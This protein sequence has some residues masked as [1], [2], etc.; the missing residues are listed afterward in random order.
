MLI[1][2]Y[3]IL[4]K[5]K[6]FFCINLLYFSLRL[7]FPLKILL[8]T[9]AKEENKYIKEFVEHY[10]KLKVN[11]IIIYDNN[12]IDSENFT[13][14]LKNE[15]SNN[16]VKIINYRGFEQPQIKAL[17]DCY[18]R[19]NKRYDWIAFYDVDEFLHII[20]YTDL[21]KFMSLKRFKKCQSILINWKYYG[22]NDL[23]YYEPKPLS[24]RFTKPFYFNSSK[25]SLKYKVS[26][27]KTIVRGGLKIEWSHLPHYLKNTINC[28]PDG[29]ILYNY[30]SPPQYSIAYLSH[31]TTKS[32]E[33]FAER[34]IRGDVFLN[35]SRKIYI[36]KRIFQY[37]FLINSKTKKKI[38][39]FRK[40]LKQKINLDLDE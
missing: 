11:K 40:I 37:Y 6:L 26:A 28:R 30:F 1:K 5:V 8:C 29:S 10:Q 23:L 19:N 21:N 4:N 31:Y 2:R 15:I 12:D 32:T 27:A 25:E 39:L 33:E 24:E 35:S 7:H 20:N 22:D 38:D 36:K 14:I 16:F 3:Y 34:L 9:I 18:E 13:D 17:N